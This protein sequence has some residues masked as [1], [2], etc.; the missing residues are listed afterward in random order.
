VFYPERNEDAAA[1]SNDRARPLQRSGQGNVSPEV[2][3][4][5][6]FYTLQLYILDL[7]VYPDGNDDETAPAKT[8]RRDSAR[9]LQRSGQGN[10]SP[11][12]KPSKSNPHTKSESSSARKFL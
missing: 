9:S 8:R 3:C 2:S 4:T 7:H 11:R 10:V 6:F 1:F 12:V 5:C